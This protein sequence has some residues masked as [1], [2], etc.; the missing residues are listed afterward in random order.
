MLKFFSLYLQPIN[1]RMMPRA[2]Q[3]DSSWINL[4]RRPTNVLTERNNRLTS[5]ALQ[6]CAHHYDR[7]QKKLKVPAQSEAVSGP[8]QCYAGQSSMKD[9]HETKLLEKELKALK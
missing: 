7:H 2:V 4:F 6:M 5:A 8:R 3:G 9:S 1:E